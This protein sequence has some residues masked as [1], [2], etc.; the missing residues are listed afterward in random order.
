MA[1]NSKVIAVFDKFGVLVDGKVVLYDD[2]ASAETAAVMA[3]H[4]EEIADRCDAFCKDAGLEG[5]NA[6]AKTRIIREFITF[7][8]KLAMVEESDEDTDEEFVPIN[9]RN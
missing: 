6:S 9:Q 2:K 4:E 5:K 3:E 7:E 8:A 1:D